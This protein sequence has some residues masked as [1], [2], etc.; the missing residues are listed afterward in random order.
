MRR[1][2]ECLLTAV[3]VLTLVCGCTPISADT[4]FFGRTEPPEGQVMRYI[5]GSEPES[6]DPHVSSGQPEA[7]LYLALYEGLMEYEPK[8]AQPIPAIAESW[9]A[10]GDN[11]EFTFHLRKNAR[12]S[13]G[14]P[15]KAQDFIYSLRRALAPALASRT[16]Y[17]AYPIR[18][19]QA[20]NELGLF[21][22]DKKTGEF[23]MEPNSTLRKTLKPEDKAPA[24]KELVPVTAEDVGVQALDDY[25][26]KYTLVQ[27]APYFVG[28]M[29]YHFFRVVHRATIERYGD[30]GWTDP[31]N[32]VTSGA[33]K[34]KE[35]V[36]YD[37]IVVVRDPMY[38]DAAAVKLDEIRFY[39]LEDQNSMMNL[40]K[41]GSVDAIYNHTVPT[42]WLESIVPMKDFMGAPEMAN[43]YVQI[44]TL[45]PPM[46]DPRVRRAFG[47]AID[48]NNLAHFMV[49]A[50]PISSFVP[51]GIFPGYPRVTGFDFDPERAKSLLAEAGYKDS[52]G[53]FDPSRFPMKD[54]EYTYNT[55]EKNKQIA[56]FLQA[57]WKQNLGL[58]VPLKNMEWK[59]FLEYRAKLEYRGLIRGAWVGDYL[60]PFTFL[61]I[62]STPTGDNGTGWWEQTYLDI[63]NDANRTTDPAKR[64]EKLTKAEN[65]LLESG[66]IISLFAPSTDWMKK[67]YVKGMYPNPS[68]SHAWK[69]VYIERDK[70]KWDY[71][72]PSLQD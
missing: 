35:W 15:I 70:A 23:E 19:A 55:S 31:K 21:V 46:D 16:A 26:L 51:E 9:E 5:S 43:T 60:D 65:M 28:L 2:L 3:L 27:S 32:I 34:L 61:N 56:E 67:P 44:N 62:F 22:R 49:T 14:D 57:Q 68:T 40:Y 20:Y 39:P 29:A 36:P 33:F 30:L 45:H 10:N 48:R 13:N 71:G 6:L 41:A 25:T 8:T 12:F 63:L 7:R 47:L 53:K 58:T 50:K 18:Y 52:A 11:S 17:M 42:A 64:F 59:T 69:Y 54:V 4:Q 72:M 38:W 1:K 24:G 37:K 66:A